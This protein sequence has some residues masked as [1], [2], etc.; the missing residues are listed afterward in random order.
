MVFSTAS[1]YSRSKLVKPLFINITNGRKIT[2]NRILFFNEK[3]F[4][5]RKTYTK[6]NEP[7]KSSAVI[8]PKKLQT[9]SIKLTLIFTHVIRLK[10][11]QIVKNIEINNKG[12]VRTRFL[13]LLKTHIERN[14]VKKIVGMCE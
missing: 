2:A 8:I 6:Y 3:S 13:L 10:T 7:I 4:L 9:K 14:N 5:F 1:Q 12:K 11:D